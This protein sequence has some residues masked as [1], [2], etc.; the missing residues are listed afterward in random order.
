VKKGEE[1]LSRSETRPSVERILEIYDSRMTQDRQLMGSVLR[2]LDPKWPTGLDGSGL[3]RII[4]K[5][6]L[7]KPRKKAIRLGKGQS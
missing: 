2:F 3:L 7:E 1:F 5:H 6:R 4:V